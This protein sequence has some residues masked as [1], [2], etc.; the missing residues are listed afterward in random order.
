MTANAFEEAQKELLRILAHHMILI[1]E[2]THIIDNQ[3]TDCDILENAYRLWSGKAVFNWDVVQVHGSQ[4]FCSCSLHCE[5]ELSPIVTDVICTP[6]I[7]FD[8]NELIDQNPAP[9][10]PPQGQMVS[11]MQT[12]KMVYPTPRLEDQVHWLDPLSFGL[13]NMSEVYAPGSSIEMHDLSTTQTSLPWPLDASDAS[14]F[15]GLGTYSAPMAPIYGLPD[16]ESPMTG[17]NDPGSGD[18]ILNSGG[19]SDLRSKSHSQELQEEESCMSAKRPKPPVDSK[20][21]TLR[22]SREFHTTAKA[23]TKRRCLNCGVPIRCTEKHVEV[24]DPI[25]CLRAWF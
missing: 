8:F 20:K 18:E 22:A 2:R 13:E 5:C 24:C 15:G 3:R 10:D 12:S 17:F 25:R 19:R 4:D 7:P 14:S 1:A 11:Q 23:H 9:E 6:S 21:G 16:F